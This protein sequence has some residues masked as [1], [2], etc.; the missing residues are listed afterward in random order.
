MTPRNDNTMSMSLPT[1]E[2]GK[3]VS[4]YDFVKS[5]DEPDRYFPD[6]EC[7]PENVVYGPDTIVLRKDDFISMREQ[8]WTL[9]DAKVGESKISTGAVKAARA[10]VQLNGN[11]FRVIRREYDVLFE[12]GTKEV[13]EHKAIVAL[14]RMHERYHV[15]PNCKSRDLIK[16]EQK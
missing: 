8:N 10:F 14:N 15:C 5:T 13:M 9:K 3:T 2:G 11:L 6:R 16:I 1:D 7:N 4:V 12:D